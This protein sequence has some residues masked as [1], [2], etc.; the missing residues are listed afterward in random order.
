MTPLKSILLAIAA[1]CLGIGYDHSI[2]LRP[3][4]IADPEIVYAASCE[5]L[6]AMKVNYSQLTERK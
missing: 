3:V 5:G 4:I 6:P 1:F 2:N